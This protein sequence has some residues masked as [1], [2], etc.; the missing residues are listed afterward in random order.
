MVIV[1]M[2]RRSIMPLSCQRSAGRRVTPSAANCQ[3]T[4]GCGRKEVM[5]PSTSG[6]DAATPRRDPDKPVACWRNRPAARI[7]VLIKRPTSSASSAPFSRNC[8]TSLTTGPHRPD[9][10][11]AETACRAVREQLGEACVWPP[12]GLVRIPGPQPDRAPCVPFHEARSPDLNP[13]PWPAPPRH[14][15]ATPIDI[16]YCDIIKPDRRQTRWHINSRW[17]IT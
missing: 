3:G 15:L 11:I 5:G 12:P 13:I 6:A 16:S 1:N 7:D 8:A 4:L 14:R 2:L 17:A 9:R 10:R